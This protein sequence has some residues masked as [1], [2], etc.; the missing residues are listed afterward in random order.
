MASKGLEVEQ[1]L[2]G[3]KTTIVDEAHVC[4]LV[5][6]SKLRS[7][8]PTSRVKT[9]GQGSLAGSTVNT[10]VTAMVGLWTHGGNREIA[11]S[12]SNQGLLHVRPIE[13]QGGLFLA[14]QAF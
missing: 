7:K 1:G 3:L 4:F 6:S 8:I 14:L 9:K 11:L 2:V 12:V 13:F 5:P 10:G